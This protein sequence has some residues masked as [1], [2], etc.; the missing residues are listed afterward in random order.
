M[1]TKLFVSAMLS[2]FFAF[3]LVSCQNNRDSDN[4]GD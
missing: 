2:F 1:K 4:N 3:F